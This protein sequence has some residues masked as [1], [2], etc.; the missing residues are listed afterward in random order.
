VHPCDFLAVASFKDEGS[1]RAIIMSSP[2]NSPSRSEGVRIRAAVNADVEALTRL[3]N[4]AF[5]VESVAF[6]GDR[7]S[8]AKV[9]AYLHTGTFLAAENAGA[10]VGCV[11]I[12]LDGDRSYL[13]LLS[14][15]PP[16]QGCG[17]GRQLVRAAEDFA[18]AAG[19]QV[20]DLRVISPRAELLP[21]YRRLGYEETRTAPFAHGVT[22]K[23]PMH[24]ILMS[25]PLA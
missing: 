1:T 6:D 21:F 17:L 23:V 3:I 13:G 19:S 10:L 4:A 5:V 16:R 25:K 12:E 22:A 15:D 2:A 9:R 18:R 24:Y 11:Y 14:V 7:V 20:M 8:A